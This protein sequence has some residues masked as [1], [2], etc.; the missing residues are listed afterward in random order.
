MK[1]L[2]EAK[3]VVCMEIER[4][5]DNGKVCLTLKGYLLKVLQ[6]FNISSDTKS[7]SIRTTLHFKLRATILLQQLKN[8]V[9]VSRT[10]CQCSGCLMYAM[11]CIRPNL[12]QAFHMVSRYMHDPGRD[13]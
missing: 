4:D 7:V 12:S 11:M 3:K 1:E 2:I 13:H 10:V 5:R 8:V 6:K 9:Y